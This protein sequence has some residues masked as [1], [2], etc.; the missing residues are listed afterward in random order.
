MKVISVLERKL[1]WLNLDKE[2]WG[3]K[4]LEEKFEIKPCEGCVTGIMVWCKRC[5]NPAIYVREDYFPKVKKWILT[6]I[7]CTCGNRYLLEGTRPIYDI[8]FEEE[9]ISFECKITFIRGGDNEW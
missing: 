5:Y 7:F 8:V 4:E 9:R 2:L 1:E 3:E 6:H